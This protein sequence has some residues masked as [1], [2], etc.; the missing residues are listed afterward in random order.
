MSKNDIVLVG[1]KIVIK[2]K[3]FC[4][5]WNKALCAVIG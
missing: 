1:Y 2:G 5:K 3:S 4:N